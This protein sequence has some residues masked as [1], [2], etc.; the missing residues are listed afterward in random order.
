MLPEDKTPK[1]KRTR[2]KKEKTPTPMA[3][4]GSGGSG[5]GT[6]RPGTRSD[7]LA[8]PPADA[9]GET[10]MR[11]L[12]E[13]NHSQIETL[14]AQIQ[15][16]GEA[17][18]KM[19]DHMTTLTDKQGEAMEN[20]TTHMSTMTEE[21]KK[22]GETVEDPAT[23]EVREAKEIAKRMRIQPPIFRGKKGERPE[24]HLLHARD[25][26]DAIGVTKE[27]DKVNYF[28]LTL[29]HLAREWYNDSGSAI[30]DW[31]EMKQEF[32]KHFSTQGKSMLNL[33]ERWRKFSFDPDEDDIEEFLRNVQEC[34]KQL[35]YDEEITLNTIKAC[36]PKAIYGSLY[37]KKTLASTIAFLKELYA[38]PLDLIPKESNAQVSGSPFNHIRQDNPDQLEGT[39]TKLSDALCKL[40]IA[41]PYKPYIAPRGRGR[42]QA[43]GRGQT[44]RGSPRSFEFQGSGKMTYPQRGHHKNR[45]RGKPTGKFDKSPT[46]RKPR[47]APKAKDMDKERCRYCKQL[48]HWRET[49]LRR[50]N[51]EMQ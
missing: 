12:L 13:V 32:S 28:R 11:W 35:K 50:R 15:K 42:G 41:R 1:G 14:Q 26:M 18:D 5:R 45:G 51:M 25:W 16:Q 21:L 37:D 22:T 44:Y 47:V 20:I 17:M 4:G 23:A 6:E 31:T 19:T 30:D 40:D 3:S 48:G 10:V 9:D 33:H 27:E 29:D 39:L 36:M 38:Q 2:G 8:L 46:Q 43:R 49:V 34:A 7:P 24:A